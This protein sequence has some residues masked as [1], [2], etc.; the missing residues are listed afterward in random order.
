MFIKTAQH[1]LILYL[2]Q[3]MEW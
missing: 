3:I 1:C 2:F